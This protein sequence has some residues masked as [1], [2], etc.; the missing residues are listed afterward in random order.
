MFVF[1]YNRCNI[2]LRIFPPD[3]SERGVVMREEY[4]QRIVELLQDC[5][6]IS[7]L[8]LIFRLLQ[9]SQQAR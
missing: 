2:L 9:K 3:T 8:D 1:S 7:L 4:V 5:N 6:D